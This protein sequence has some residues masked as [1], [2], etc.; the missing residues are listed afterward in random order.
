MKNICLSGMSRTVSPLR[1]SVSGLDTCSVTIITP[2]R[3]YD[4]SNGFNDKYA[5]DKIRLEQAIGL[6]KNKT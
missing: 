2:L 6:L 1:G 4:G 5:H 3:G